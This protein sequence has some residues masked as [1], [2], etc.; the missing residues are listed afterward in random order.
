MP[1]RGD[2]TRRFADGTAVAP[3]AEPR[4]A[5][6]PTRRAY[7]KSGSR[8]ATQAVDRGTMVASIVVQRRT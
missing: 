4:T 3:P 7:L 1:G 6:R 8:R 5:A 2:R